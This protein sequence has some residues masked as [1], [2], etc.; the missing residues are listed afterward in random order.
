MTVL[1]IRVQIGGIRIILLDRYQFQANEK[2]DKLNFLPENLFMLSKILK[3]ITH[4][5]L[6]REIKH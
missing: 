5:K 6:M 1:L 4:V 2:V 3:I